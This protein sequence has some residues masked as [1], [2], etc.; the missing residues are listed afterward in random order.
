MAPGCVAGVVLIAGFFELSRMAL[1]DWSV[2]P[3]E[4]GS[5]ITRVNDTCGCWVLEDTRYVTMDVGSPLMI[6]GVE[7]TLG[8]PF[9]V[10]WSSTNGSEWSGMTCSG[11]EPICVFSRVVEAQMVRITVQNFDTWSGDIPDFAAAPLGVFNC[12]DAPS[13]TITTI[14]T[15]ALT[16]TTTTANPTTTTTTT[17]NPTTTALTTTTTTAPTTTAL[18]PTTTAVVSEARTTIVTSGSATSTETTPPLQPRFSVVWGLNR[19]GSGDTSV[20]GSVI[21]DGLIWNVSALHPTLGTIGVDVYYAPCDPSNVFNATQWLGSILELYG[22]ETH[23]ALQTLVRTHCEENQPKI[24]V[25]P[26]TARMESLLGVQLL[27]VFLV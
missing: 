13:T 12:T 2:F 25:V 23:S 9:Q 1:V 19:G 22:V 24:W 15:T 17:A 21:S 14:T 11:E 18:T 26:R 16:T 20:L 8:Y 10:E 3:S 5:N 7:T 4:V 27:P 6:G